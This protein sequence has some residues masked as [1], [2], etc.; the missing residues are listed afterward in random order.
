MTIEEMTQTKEVD[1]TNKIYTQENMRRAIIF[2]R[3]QATLSISE[4]SYITLIGEDILKG[5]ELGEEGITYEEFIHIMSAM[6]A[7][8]DMLKCDFPR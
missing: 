2:Y 7:P 3:G 5:M 6:D 1:M 4:L 8:W